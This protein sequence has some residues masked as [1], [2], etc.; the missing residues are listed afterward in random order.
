MMTAEKFNSYSKADR[1]K[2][3]CQLYQKLEEKDSL[4]AEHVVTVSEFLKKTA[5]VTTTLSIITPTINTSAKNDVFIRKF[6]TLKVE[7]KIEN[8]FIGSSIIEHLTRDRTFPQ[9]CSIH[10][11]PCSTTN[12]KLQLKHGYDQ[13]KMKT[14]ILQ[15]GTNAILKQKS[16]HLDKILTD[17]KDLVSSIK[18]KFSPKALVLMEVPPLK[19]LPKNEQTNN[20]IFEF[21]EKLRKYI[22]KYS[23][24][25]T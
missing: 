4:I 19:K 21:N 5:Q 11:Y 9:D 13:K 17:Y 24:S 16:D 14:V 1:Y 10:A 2:I 23:L 7:E 3:Y 8:F 12:E 22:S 25:A 15:H 18:E 20:K 6:E